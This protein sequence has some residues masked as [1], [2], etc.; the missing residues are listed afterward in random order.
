MRKIYVAIAF[1]SIALFTSAQ[2]FDLS[3]RAILNQYKYEQKA[4]NPFISEKGVDNKITPFDNNA[5]KVLTIVKLNDDSDISELEAEGA[6]IRSVREDLAIVEMR[7]ANIEKLSTLNSVE[8]ISMPHQLKTNMDYARMDAGINT[9]HRP[10]GILNKAYKGNGI[11]TGLVDVGVTANHPNFIN[12][13]NDTY[14]V[15]CAYTISGTDGNITAFD[16]EEKLGLYTTDLATETHG[17]HVAGIMSGSYKNLADTVNYYGVATESDIV[18]VGLG[19]DTY[20]INLLLGI[21]KVIEYAKKEGKPAVINLSLGNNFGAHDGTSLTCQY[22]NQLAK[23][24]VICLAAGNEADEQ[25]SIIKTFTETDKEVKTFFMPSYYENGQQG[26]VEIWSDSNEPFSVTPIL[27]D[28]TTKNIIGQLP[29]TTKST[30]GNYKYVSTPGYVAEDDIENEMFDVAFD[31]YFGTASEIDNINNRYNCTFHYSLLNDPNSNPNGNIVLGLIVTGKSGQR[32]DLCSPAGYTAFSSYDV[33]GWTSGG[34]NGS[35]SDMACAKDIISVGAHITRNTIPV[36]VKGGYFDFSKV[37]TTNDIAPFSSYSDL[38]D[39]RKLP[40]ITAPGLMISS[41]SPYYANLAIGQI[42]PNEYYYS[43]KTIYKNNPYYYEYMAGTSMASPFV[44]GVAALMLEACPTL[45][46]I[47]VR[48]ILIETATKDEFVT[49]ATTP[50]Q[51]GAGKINAT[52]ALKK[53]IEYASV[54]GIEIDP[55]KRIHVTND[56]NNIFEISVIGENTINATL[57][58][59]SGQPIANTSAQGDTA[60]IDASNVNKGIYILVVESDDARLT[61][62]IVVK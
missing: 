41:I 59:L 37:F 26:L 28:I 54:T 25:I 56:G 10:L 40:N 19:Q 20:D 27:F 55:E 39:G 50:T 36:R 47:D 12:T 33:P 31:G 46:C 3:S 32:I 18:M 57:F 35:I 11:V 38:V 9:V 13:E 58:N 1:A 53:A 16:T 2:K 61:T 8:R 24:A 14:R 21:E 34:G 4:K 23:E 7:I 44:A 52:A 22:L 49:N 43:A 60:I 48:N 15:K 29:T 30:N 6:I 42:Y 5:E 45:S 17:T 62:R 51:F